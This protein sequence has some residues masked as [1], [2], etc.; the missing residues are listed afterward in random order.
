M[1]LPLPSNRFRA[2]VREWYF[3]GHVSKTVFCIWGQNNLEYF[4]EETYTES[5]PGMGRGSKIPDIVPL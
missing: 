4:G 3:N 5:I 1:Y 2:F